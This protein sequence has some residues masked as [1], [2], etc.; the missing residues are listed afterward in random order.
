MP[1]R[2]VSPDVSRP[3][4]AWRPR[5][6]RLMNLRDLSYLVAI[7]EH[8][9]FG[10]AAEACFVSQ[11]TLSTQLKKLEDELGVELIERSPRH[12]MLTEAG[13]LVVERAKVVL[14]EAETFIPVVIET[15]HS[16]FP[17][18]GE[19]K[20]DVVGILLAKELLNYYRNPDGF[21][22]RDT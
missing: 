1:S 21:S 16:R 20:D 19:S 11:P 13:R 15:K 18:I 22:L 17:V 4:R 12:V 6:D 7:S 8:R 2:S 14:D 10:R 9:H 5:G 3:T